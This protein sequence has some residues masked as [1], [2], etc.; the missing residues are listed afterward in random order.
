[1]DFVKIPQRTYGLGRFPVTQR[2]WLDLMGTAP[3]RGR[4]LG[5]EDG[6]CPATFVSWEDC[7]ALVARLNAGEGRDAFR[8]PGEDEWLHAC[9]AG[10]PFKYCFGDDASG[11]GDYAWYEANAYAVGERHAHP[12]GQKAPNAWGLHDMHGNVWEWTRTLEDPQRRI[13]RGGAF[14]SSAARCLYRYRFKITSRFCSLGVRLLWQ[15]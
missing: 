10:S 11:L 9:L 3:W 15:P 4:K 1:M 12:V 13:A 5:H 14:N 8:L 6:D 7:Q 2:E